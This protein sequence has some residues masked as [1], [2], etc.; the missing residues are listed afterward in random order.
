MR[1]E[2]SERRNPMKIIRGKGKETLHEKEGTEIMREEGR[3]RKLLEGR[4]MI[5]KE[6]GNEMLKEKN[7][8]NEK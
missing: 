4:E 7:L 2:G 5:F 6:K 8:V 3:K 1:E